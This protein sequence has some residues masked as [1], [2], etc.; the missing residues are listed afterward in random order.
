[1]QELDCHRTSKTEMFDDL[2]THVDELG[3]AVCP[4][5]GHFSP[6]YLKTFTGN[7]GKNIA[8]FAYVAVN[9]IFPVVFYV[10]LNYIFVK[11]L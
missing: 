9:G 5:S 10:F 7:S 2:A 8:G 11:I 1:M 6:H 4:C 3:V